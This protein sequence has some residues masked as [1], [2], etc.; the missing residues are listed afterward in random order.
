MGDWPAAEAA[1]MEVWLSGSA[2][3][4]GMQMA[5]RRALAV[6]REEIASAIEETIGG[7]PG[8]GAERPKVEVGQHVND[9]QWAA[10]IA[11]DYGEKG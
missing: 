5:V 6:Q 8:N 4:T 10:R 7:Y 9:A 1:A 3:T 11:R 2:D